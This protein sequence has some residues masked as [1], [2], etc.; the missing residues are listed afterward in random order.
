MA[1]GFTPRQYDFFSLLFG[2]GDKE[3]STASWDDESETEPIDGKFEPTSEKS[4]LEAIRDG[5]NLIETANDNSSNSSPSS[6][7]LPT[8]AIAQEDESEEDESEEDDEEE[9]SIIDFLLNGEKI[10][11]S[12]TA[13]P[14]NT[15]INLSSSNEE[16]PSFTN[17][18][19]HIQPVL[20]DEMQN[21]T[22]KFALLPMS[23]YN[24]VKDDGSIVFDRNNR[25][26]IS[27][28]TPIVGINAEEIDTTTITD[29]T[30][31]EELS[32]AN[33]S[34]DGDENKTTSGSTA[35]T[36]AVTETKTLRSEAEWTSTIETTSVE[37]TTIASAEST[38][39]SNNLTELSSTTVTIRKNEKQKIE[40]T[41]STV[42]PNIVTKQTTIA[43]PS[44]ETAQKFATTTL[45][46]ETSASTLIASTESGNHLTTMH[47]PVVID[48]NPSILETD[49]N[50]DYSE[51]TLPPSLPNLKIIPFLPTDAV[52]PVES[53]SRQKIINYLSQSNPYSGGAS[54]SIEN[55][56]ANYSPFNVK[57]ATEKYP[58]YNGQVQL[59][60]DRLDYDGYNGPGE[61]NLANIDYSNVYSISGIGSSNA[62]NVISAG[63]PFVHGG[64]DSK[65]EFG[66]FTQKINSNPPP[67]KTIATTTVKNILNINRFERPYNDLFQ[68]PR[69][70][71]TTNTRP[72]DI[73]NYNNNPI[74]NKY[75]D[76]TYLAPYQRQPDFDEDYALLNE[77]PIKHTIGVG[78]AAPP[79]PLFSY[80]GKNN[81]M[82]PLQTEGEIF[83]NNTYIT[84]T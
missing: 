79:K 24:M 38:A 31:T 63:V 22:M 53:F 3:N 42:V 16:A 46:L 56:N 27:A 48:S 58:V 69:P 1:R 55:T 80:S 30:Y 36:N 15:V 71:P 8:T 76:D 43:I 17:S 13:N 64:V 54:S 77:P 37:T 84:P 52:K 45:D 4:F 49:L 12:T 51:P 65:L 78:G 73:F 40:T 41:E 35:T 66:S 60:G 70:R 33:T 19:M 25:T 75:A 26:Q 61:D 23:L 44:N 57:P 47:P 50:Y 81:F 5:L 82:P 21:G 9:I 62:N 29:A 34:I 10:F 74:S 83:S 67:R 14:L 11:S 18:P 68:V 7:D 20:P 59:A 2:G 32:T 72:T 6:A 39:T 28:R